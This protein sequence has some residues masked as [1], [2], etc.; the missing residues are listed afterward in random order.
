MRRNTGTRHTDHAGSTE[1][2]VLVNGVTASIGGAYL[3]TSSVLITVLAGV[4][5]VAVAALHVIFGS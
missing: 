5:A 3:L 1:V 2:V 4:A